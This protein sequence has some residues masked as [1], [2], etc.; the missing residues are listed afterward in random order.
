[1]GG[2]R[3]PGD[4]SITHRALL[5]AA[6]SSG[7]CRFRGALAA[8]DTRA[9]A[10]ALRALG[11]SVGPLSGERVVSVTGGGLHPFRA[12]E[13]PID[14]RSSGTTARLLLGL[15]AGHPF[16]TA[17]TGDRGLRRRPLGRVA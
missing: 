9:A 14:C 6:L 8:G 1:M 4:K 2:I 15:L 7:K 12:C 11:V 3:V 13:G 5:L 10:A 17:L 16:E